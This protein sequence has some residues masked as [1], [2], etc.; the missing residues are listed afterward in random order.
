MNNTA[1]TT[2]TFTPTAGQCAT[3]TTLTITVNPNVIPTFTAIAAICSGATLTALPTTSLNGITGAWTPALNNTATTTYTFTPTAGQCAT[4]TAL[5]ISVNPS[6]QP[7]AGNDVKTCFGNNVQLQGSGGSV[8]HWSPATYLSGTEIANPVV[9]F[10]P[11]GTFTY[12]LDVTDINGC[13]SRKP[14]TVLVTILP[15]VNVF[16]GY[17]TLIAINQPLQLNAIDVNNSGF[18]SYT[19][20]PSVGLNNAS[21]QNPVAVL[22]N[23]ITYTVIARTP[24]NCTAQDD[25]NIKV[26]LGPEIYVPTGF[27]PNND[28]LNDIIKPTLIGIRELKY[29]AIYN[30][31]GEQVYI[32]S[33]KGKG[34]NGVYKGQLQNSAAFVW[35]TQAV[36][37]RGNILKRKGTVVLIR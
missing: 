29:F 34:W 9:V 27:T 21:I 22:N 25:I 23:D 32:T 17:D 35:V 6:P 33:E 1:T 11:Q 18:T 4:T 12:L 2:Y 16:A 8:F 30:R 20:S 31:Y 37:Y 24:E 19:W 13:K 14:D 15:P 7:N 26:F 5:T 36:D 3:T 10:A 28:G